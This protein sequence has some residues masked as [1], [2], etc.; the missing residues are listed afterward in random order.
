MQSMKIVKKPTLI[1]EADKMPV[2]EG[3]SDFN[4]IQIKYNYEEY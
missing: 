3:K 4:N 2:K 1:A